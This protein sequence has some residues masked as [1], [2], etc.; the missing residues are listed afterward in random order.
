MKLGLSS[1][2][3][4][5]PSALEDLLGKKL[6]DTKTALITNSKDYYSDFARSAK[7]NISLNKLS[8]SGLV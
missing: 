5:V 2:M 1:Y 3:I 8:T 7:I 6:S 4:P